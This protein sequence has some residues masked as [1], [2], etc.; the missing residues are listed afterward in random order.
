MLDLVYLGLVVA[1]LTLA[2]AALLLM[3]VRS[4]RTHADARAERRRV[5][6][7]RAQQRPAGLRKRSEPM[8]EPASIAS[9]TDVRS[10]GR[11]VVAALANDPKPES[12]KPSLEQLS[13][14]V[15]ALAKRPPEAD[16][17]ARPRVGAAAAETKH[18]PDC[19]E[20]VLA[21]ARVC[22]HCRYRFDE[23]QLDKRLSA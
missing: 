1:P 14:I 4:F 8:A 9:V 16:L 23:D 11:S 6:V 7:E 3:A 13:A 15:E 10:L 19:A 20:E 2:G 18:C 5:D 12:D 21:A 22:K 17:S